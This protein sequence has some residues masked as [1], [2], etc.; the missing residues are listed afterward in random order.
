[1]RV[2]FYICAILYSFALN[3]SHI[4]KI[5]LIVMLAT[6]LKVLNIFIFQA[7]ATEI[8]TNAYVSTKKY[9]PLASYSANK[10]YLAWY[11]LLGFS[12]VLVRVECGQHRKCQH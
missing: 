2:Y 5:Q 1:M 6:F 7:E 3:H 8:E 9:I 10:L 4:D 12:L 11:I